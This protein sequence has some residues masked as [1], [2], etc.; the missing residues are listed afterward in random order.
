MM[1]VSQGAPPVPGMLSL[2]EF[3]AVYRAGRAGPGSRVY[4]V[5]GD[6]VDRSLS[7][8]LHNWFFARKGTADLY[9]PLPAPDPADF[10]AAV[11]A[12]GPAGLSVT[13]P[14]K[15]R[16]LAECAE[17]T[18]DARRV[19]AV[20]TLTATPRGWEGDNTD[21][22]G[23][24]RSLEGWLPPGRN[25][26]VVLGAGGTARA[27]LHALERRGAPAGCWNRDPARLVGLLRDFPAARAMGAPPAGADVVVNAT[28]ASAAGELPMPAPALAALQAEYA[29]DVAY[30]PVPSP[31]LRLAAGRGWHVRDGLPMLFHQAAAQHRRWTGSDPAANWEEARALVE[32]HW[33]R[34]REIGGSAA[35]AW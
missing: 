23:F 1:Y 26:F 20:N 14:H 25:R 31:F 17:L 10:R 11:D 13:V 32:S 12:I 6:P 2:Y 28:S 22:L 15:E 21:W 3:E 16:W 33:R 5:V 19:G 8:L 35:P 34:S 29:L 9:L 24:E 27:V 4:G 18:P 30:G 7:P